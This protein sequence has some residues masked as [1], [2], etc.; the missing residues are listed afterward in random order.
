MYK[1]SSV[2]VLTTRNYTQLFLLGLLLK[3]I[4]CLSFDPIVQQQWFIPFLS[5]VLNHPSIDP[6]S[7]FVSTHESLNFPYGPIM[8]L[9]IMIGILFAKICGTIVTLN[10]V[11][12]GLRITILTADFILL[13]V[14]DKLFPNNTKKFIL[15]YWLSPITFIANYWIGQLDIIPVAILTTSFFFLRKHNF[16]YSGITLAAAL[17]AK[18][19]MAVV[20]PFFFLYFIKNKRLSDYYLPFSIGFCIIFIPFFILPSLSPGYR[21]M[22]LSTPELGRLLEL[23]FQLGEMPIFLTPILYG[24]ILYATWRIPR[25]AFDLFYAMVGCSF[26]ILLLTT[27]TPPGWYLW[28]IPFLSRHL[29][30]SPPYSSQRWLGVVFSF[31]ALGCQVL[32]WQP[33]IVTFSANPFFFQHIL[34]IQFVKTMMPYWYTVTTFFGLVVITGIIREGVLKNDLFLIGKRPITISIAGD[35]GTG[36]DTCAQSI[37]KL[38]GKQSV[39]HVNGDDYHLWDRYAPM[40][41]RFTHLSP[42][43]N[44]FRRFYH[45]ILA[46][47]SRKP[48]LGQRYD[49]H[50]GHFFPPAY[51]KSSDFIIITGLHALYNHHLNTL[52]DLRIFLDMDETLRTFL[53]CKRDTLE[54]G[55]TLQN[56]LSS[57]Q[58]RE[59]DSI[60]YIHPQKDNAHIIFSL[61]AISI[62]NPQLE[63]FSHTPHLC[64]SVTLK[65]SLYHES[66]I[67][68]LIMLSTLHITTEPGDVHTEHKIIIEGNCSKESIAAIANK[69][70]PKLEEILTIHPFWENDL[71]GIIQL[72]ILCHLFQNCKERK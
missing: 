40:W 16:I 2:M 10:A 65:N 57:I 37:V 60:R 22:V 56:V 21:E 43:A 64:L 5:H 28:F 39:V 26:L 54:R 42:Q 50:T 34:D 45:D 35:S 36:K 15:W 17:S 32:F 61:K 6:W 51:Q 53:K 27:I 12:F 63:D 30:E 52:F 20:T 33:P 72:I 4:G 41:K 59:K 1:K 25:M 14:L 46:A 68:H 23:H 70:V 58:R 29:A 47:L 69:M 3:I 13:I 44:D 31:M 55:H 18:M 24:G 9:P 67:R 38:L 19:S 62:L 11:T 71:M 49:H 48:I 7:S 8:L 66:L